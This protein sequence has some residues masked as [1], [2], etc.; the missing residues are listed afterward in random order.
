[1]IDTHT[2]SHT[3]VH[4]HVYMIDHIQHTYI[5]RADYCRAAAMRACTLRAAFLR[6]RVI[7][8]DPLLPGPRRPAERAVYAAIY[9][10]HS[11]CERRAT[12]AQFV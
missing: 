2:H 7:D 1:M 12:A 4:V 8:A 3:H 6:F 5:S 9:I 11:T 10:I